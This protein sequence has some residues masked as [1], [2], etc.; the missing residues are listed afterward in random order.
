MI[1]EKYGVSAKREM[2]FSWIAVSGEQGGPSPVFPWDC[3]GLIDLFFSCWTIQFQT[4]STLILSVMTCIT[5]F[6]FFWVTR[7]LCLESKISQC[8]WKRLRRRAA[9]FSKLW[10]FF[11]ATF[12]RHCLLWSCQPCFFFVFFFLW[13]KLKEL[14]DRTLNCSFNDS[15]TATLELKNVLCNSK[16]MPT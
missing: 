15:L 8:T 11:W 16:L 6:F 13:R 10:P 4:S 1:P 5:T 3:L 14:W 12:S 7:L 2:T 9:S